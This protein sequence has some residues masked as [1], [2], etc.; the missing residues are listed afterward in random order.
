[1]ADIAK[2][3]FQA[4]TKALEDAVAKLNKIKPA[5][6]GAQDSANQLSKAAA[7]AS[8]Q[9]QKAAVTAAKAEAS[10]AQA[11][12]NTARA[13]ATASKQDIAAAAAANKKAQAAYSNAKAE[14]DRTTAIIA[15]MNAEK[16]MQKVTDA[17]TNALMRQDAALNEVAAGLGRVG[18]GGGA[19]GGVPVNPAVPAND[20]MPNRFNTAN[21]AAQFQDIG[22]TAAMGMNPLTIALQ[23]GTQLSAILNSMESPL[24]GI[25]VAFRSIINP[26]SLTSIALV[27]LIAGGLQLVDWISVGKSALNTLADGMQFV[28]DNAGALSVAFLGLSVSMLALNW[29]S[30]ITGL[31]TATVTMAALAA[32]TW[33]VIAP[34]VAAGAAAAAFAGILYAVFGQDFI[35]AVKTG[36]N[37]GIALMVGFFKSIAGLFTSTSL[38]KI[39]V[40]AFAFA[41]NAVGALIETAINGW[42]AVIN[43]FLDRLPQSM[44][45]KLGINLL[46]DVDI[47]SVYNPLIEGGVE[48]ASIIADSFRESF[49]TDWVGVTSEAVESAAQAAVGKLRNLAS[50]LGD[51]EKKKRGKTDAE[52]YQDVIDAANRR[53]ETL[54]AEQ[55]ALGLTALEAEKL[56]RYTEMLNSAQQKGLTLTD[57][58]KNELRDLAGEMAVL[59]EETRKTE[60]VLDFMKSTSKS[61]F[62]DMKGSLQEGESLW[63]SFSNAVVN[64][65]DRM[66]E[67]FLQASL[68]GLFDSSIGAFGG[69]GGSSWL[70]DIGSFLFSAKGNAFANDNVV[71]FAKGGAF[72][73]SIVSKPTMFAYG[74]SFG[75]MGEAGAEAVMPLGRTGD[76]SLGVKV[77]DSGMSGGG[78]NVVVNVYNNSSAKATVNQRQTANG[79]E[80]DVLVDETVAQ[81][82]SEQG[83][84]SSRALNNRD[85][86]GYI[87]R[88]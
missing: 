41:L 47:P 10:K 45:D 74:D 3:G 4:D 39:F 50:G 18:R 84:A 38:S 8:L 35:N 37:T 71:P 42:I 63:D 32:S 14:R 85:N 66:L 29:S 21:I 5:A 48:A 33:G 19:G 23:Q 67:K 82:M 11:V 81:K 17:T 2:I 31:K 13:S 52:K 24:K 51:E 9:V 25:A 72:T 75:V 77:A 12:Y 83:S 44:K 54:H 28:A 79:M 58:Q 15:A 78:G 40:G 59:S 7:A 20:A 88:G 87:R 22:V 1:M 34:F 61:F 27:G 16:Q 43:G 46:S 80:L 76:G 64:A 68:D 62:S 86:R 65:L 30:L 49:G 60:E 73:N 53:I 56:T 55:E 69:N 70:T 36:V 26:V 6:K 57:A